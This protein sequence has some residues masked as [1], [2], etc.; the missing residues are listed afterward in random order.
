MKNIYKGK[1]VLVTGHTGFKGSWIVMWLNHMGAK[2]IGLSDKVPTNPSLFSTANL[3]SRI[4]D[5]RVDIRDL[6]AVSNAVDTAKPDIIF[7]LAAQALVADSYSDPVTTIQTN[8]IGT[9]NILESIR[10]LNRKVTAIMITSDKVYDNVEWIWGYK[11]SDVI[12]G[13][14][15]YSASKGLAELILKSYFHSY[16]NTK[17]SKVRICIARAGNVIGGGDWAANRIVPDSMKAWAKNNPVILRN[18]E[19]TRP[20]QHVLEPIGGYLLLGSL[21][22]QDLKLN[23]EAFNF[24][25]NDEAD[26]SVKDL[27]S[28]MSVFWKNSM[29]KEHKNPKFNFKEARLLKL[30]C[31][32]SRAILGWSPVLNFNETAMLTTNWYKS[33]YSKSDQNPYELAMSD[34]LKY[35]E[36][37]KLKKIGW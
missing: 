24:G 8:A 31:D 35:L 30:N 22:Y 32:K 11:E 10:M 33:F 15:P 23:G 3:T 14:D 9:M 36:L 34:I 1:T 29:W 18:P 16:F 28:A 25:P 19:S 37:K 12:G 4:Q 27:I 26:H 6:K 21:L 13:K 5:L 20:W 2:V 17:Q 7:H